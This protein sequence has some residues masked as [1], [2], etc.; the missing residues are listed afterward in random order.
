MTAL[1]REQVVDRRDQR[2]RRPASTSTAVSTKRS[3]ARRFAG[4][5]ARAGAAP[6]AG[7]ER[8][9]PPLAGGD[10]LGRPGRSFHGFQQAARSGAGRRAPARTSVAHSRR[11]SRDD[12]ASGSG[13]RMY[14]AS[15]QRARDGDRQ[16]RPAG[17][18]DPVV[19]AP[20]APQ[21]V[22]DRSATSAAF[23]RSW[24][25]GNTPGLPSRW[26]SSVAKLSRGDEG[27]VAVERRHDVDPMD[28][29]GR[30]GDERPEQRGGE[31]ADDRREPAA[32]EDH[33]RA[34]ARRR[35]P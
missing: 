29:E 33:E 20:G 22:H 35:W 24:S 25:T 7:L 27:R 30:V 23:S 4:A 18:R 17:R 16:Q 2:G 21:Q 14:Q 31:R 13:Q 19:A 9:R 8:S 5:L 15:S 1:W 3:A 6:R 34:A 32:R 11:R 12:A 26:A 10:R 28:A